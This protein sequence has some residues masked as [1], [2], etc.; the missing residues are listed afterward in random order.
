M[1][2]ITQTRC[3]CV[4]NCVLGKMC[5]IQDPKLLLIQ[6]F[7]V[8][9]KLEKSASE[10]YSLS[11]DHKANFTSKFSLSKLVCILQIGESLMLRNTIHNHQLLCERR[12]LDVISK[13][14]MHA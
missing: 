10:L 9:D 7:K 4:L 12:A 3:A 14:N 8:V 5:Q 2:A 11:N 1:I 6:D 13:C